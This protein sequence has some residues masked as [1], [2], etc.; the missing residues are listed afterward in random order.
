MFCNFRNE[1]LHL[2]SWAEARKAIETT[3][4]STDT[5]ELSK[6]KLMYNHTY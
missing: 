3:T 1:C 4:G 2:T 5:T 6:V